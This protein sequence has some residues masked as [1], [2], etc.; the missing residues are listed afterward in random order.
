VLLTFHRYCSNA[1]LF[2][3][4]FLSYVNEIFNFYCS[5]D[6]NVEDFAGPLDPPYPAVQPVTIVRGSVP[7]QGFRQTTSYTELVLPPGYVDTDNYKR[8]H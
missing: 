8:T 7:P 2:I 4:S 3:T 1:K 5:S 6:M